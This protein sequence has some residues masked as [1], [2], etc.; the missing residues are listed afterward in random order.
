M[1]VFDGWVRKAHN[2][3]PPYPLQVRLS[4]H[5]GTVSWTFVDPDTADGQAVFV[6]ITYTSLRGER[7]CFRITKKEHE[8]LFKYYYEMYQQIFTVGSRLLE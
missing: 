4:R 6:P 1:E 8:P 3:K 5:I 2:R 7:P